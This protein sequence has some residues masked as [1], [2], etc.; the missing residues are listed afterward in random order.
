MSKN[1][2]AE[3]RE[4]KRLPPVFKKIFKEPLATVDRTIEKYETSLLR[5][6]FS[7]DR[8]INVPETKISISLKWYTDNEPPTFYFFIEGAVGPRVFGGVDPEMAK[9]LPFSSMTID[10]VAKKLD[11]FLL[12]YQYDKFLTFYE[13]RTQSLFHRFCEFVLD[14]TIIKKVSSLEQQEIDEVGRERLPGEKEWYKMDVFKKTDKDDGKVILDGYCFS[15]AKN[16]AEDIRTIRVLYS[17]NHFSVKEDV[18]QF[19][20][21]SQTIVKLPKDYCSGLTREDMAERFLVAYRAAEETKTN[22]AEVMN[23]LWKLEDVLGP[24]PKEALVP[25]VEAYSAMGCPPLFKGSLG[26][27]PCLFIQKE[28]SDEPSIIVAKPF[29]PQKEARDLLIKKF[30]GTCILEKKWPIQ[31]VVSLRDTFAAEETAQKFPNPTIKTLSGN[32]GKTERTSD[33]R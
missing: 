21:R 9:T 30:I 18:I 17:S 11:K 15:G 28:G 25:V 1:L 29:P 12:L 23:G 27:R 14:E 10:N 2:E 8:T 20:I 3:E 33:E 7:D 26:E 24:L 16:F 4:E 13:N 5:S 19:A 31:R 22:P 6:F 32:W